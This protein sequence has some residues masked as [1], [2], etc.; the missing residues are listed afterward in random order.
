MF[1]NVEFCRR[2]A[3]F[4]NSL[5]SNLMIKSKPVLISHHGND[6]L[7]HRDFTALTGVYQPEPLLGDDRKHRN[8]PIILHV[9]SKVCQSVLTLW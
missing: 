6:Q 4:R 9:M 7:S 8:K 1:N 5:V 3:T 2:P